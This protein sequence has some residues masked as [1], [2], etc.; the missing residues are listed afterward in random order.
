M[1]LV[2]LHVLLL[3]TGVRLQC[4][5]LSMPNAVM[6]SI[7]WTDIDM[8]ELGEDCNPPTQYQFSFKASQY[9]SHCDHHEIHILLTARGRGNSFA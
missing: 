2:S 8:L 4:G 9:C 3:L 7:T 6:H 1:M 5:Y